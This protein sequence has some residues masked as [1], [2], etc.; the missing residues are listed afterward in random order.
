[1]TSDKRRTEKETLLTRAKKWEAHFMQVS[2]PA[3]QFPCQY[4]CAVLSRSRGLLLI[5]KK[6]KKMNNQFTSRQ[7][8]EMSKGFTPSG[9]SPNRKQRKE[10]EGKLFSF[11]G[12]TNNRRKT[13]GRKVQ[14]IVT[15]NS[16][17]RIIHKRF[18]LN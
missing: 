9:D 3:H 18:E 17:K 1:M 10:S 7:V 14:L 16:S 13:R 11:G 4:N 6:Q 15:G 5:T 2:S 8:Q 12:I